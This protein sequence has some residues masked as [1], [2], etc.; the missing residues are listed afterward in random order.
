MKPS[1]RIGFLPSN[2]EAWDGPL[3]DG[4]RWARAMRDRVVDVLTGV[5]GLDLVAP[6]V[7]LTGDGWR[8]L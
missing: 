6:S 8:W 7:E 3:Q 5:D 1:V 2:W 4:S